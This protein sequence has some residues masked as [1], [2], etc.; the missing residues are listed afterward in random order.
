MNNSNFSNKNCSIVITILNENDTII[1][2]FNNLLNVVMKYKKDPNF[3]NLPDIGEIIFVDGGSIDGT[4]EKLKSILDT[5]Y[6]KR[7]GII[8]KILVQ[9]QG[10][11]LAYAEYFGISSA[12]GDYVLKMDGDNQHPPD[13]IIEL[14]KRS[15]QSDIVIA[16]RYVKGGG[17]FWK[18]MRG[19]ISRIA[20]SEAHFFIKNV[21][22]VHDPL[23]GF[24]LLKKSYKPDSPP[25]VYG[26][27]YLLFILSCSKDA[28]ISE[29]PFFM[30]E[31]SKGNSKILN[32]VKDMIIEFNLELLYIAK[33]SKLREVKRENELKT[34]I[35]IVSR[36][37]FNL[38]Q[39][40]GADK[41]AVSNV[42]ELLSSGS[43][44]LEITFIGRTNAFKENSNVKIISIP[45]NLS[46][47]SSGELRY[48]LKG[49]FLN[50]MGAI[51][52]VK[53]LHSHKD[54][55]IVFTHSN[56]SSILIKFLNRRAIVTYT[57]HD[58][59]FTKDE[60]LGAKEIF[61]RIL[62]NFLLERIAV[63]FSDNI[64]VVSPRIM[65]QLPIKHRK[66][67]NIKYP[68]TL[69][70]QGI[71]AISNINSISAAYYNKITNY[72]LSAGFQ[73]GRKKFDLL[74]KSWKY[75][76]KDLKLIIVGDGP[77]H[78]ELID[79][80]SPE[81]KDRIIFL[82]NLSDTELETLIS[83]AQ[84]GILMSVREGFPTFVLQCLS[85][86]IPSIFLTTGELESYNEIR[87]NYLLID[88]MAD[89]STN[90]AKINSYFRQIPSV[91]KDEVRQ[92]AHKTFSSSNN[93]VDYLTIIEKK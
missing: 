56:V 34:K 50:I 18:P 84:F 39:E 27:K 72:A 77:E 30:K 38:D 26:F 71:T 86:G 78:E 9:R 31:R 91:S 59:L 12:I 23:S 16:S 61:A 5:P 4:I 49:F 52:S 51:L 80:V 46:I 65:Y 25:Y 53:F 35:L 10:T 93:L 22:N 87:S 62:N 11:R 40:G 44:N 81:M 88:Q 20:R 74:I 14:L 24:Y 68:P 17:N 60:I 47:R 69:F 29:V 89:E 92:W 66:K 48:F 55:K 41:Y 15:S 2:F 90:A 42:Y 73:N 6:V 19:L 58:Q 67:I 1:E 3:S 76:T 36:G 63:S 32:S 64:V 83:G 43:K 7:T 70:R 54:Y 37:S 82:K 85:N 13:L 57:I 79:S 28:V 75:V 21:K 45:S 33:H 8:L